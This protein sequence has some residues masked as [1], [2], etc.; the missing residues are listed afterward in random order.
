MDK[1]K[2]K[3]HTSV[4]PPFGDTYNM[5]KL[6]QFN[7]KKEQMILIPAKYNPKCTKEIN[8]LFSRR[9]TVFFP[10]FFSKN[11]KKSINLV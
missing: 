6:Q 4:P 10:K 2:I 3:K 1:K 11:E 8:L 9:F 7:F 5:Y